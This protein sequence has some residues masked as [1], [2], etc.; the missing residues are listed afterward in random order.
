MS[1]TDPATVLQLAP[2]YIFGCRFRGVP[3]GFPIEQMKQPSGFRVGSAPESDPTWDIQSRAIRSLR[4]FRQLGFPVIAPQNIASTKGNSP[5]MSQLEMMFQ[6][7]RKSREPCLWR[8]CKPRSC[9]EHRQQHRHQPWYDKWERVNFS[10][11]NWPQ[12]KPK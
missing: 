1:S 4:V 2:F 8:I 10:P 6:A 9:S 5:E 3:A 11:Q 7:S 12:P